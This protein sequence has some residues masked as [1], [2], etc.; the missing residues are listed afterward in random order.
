MP[1]L[2][3]KYSDPALNPANKDF[4]EIVN[5][6]DMQALNDQGDATARESNKLGRA[7]KKASESPETTGRV[8]DPRTAEKDPSGFW[9]S[10]TKE[11]RVRGAFTRYRHNKKALIATGAVGG[12]ILS[13]IA[14]FFALL[15]LKFEMLIKAA[16]DQAAQV[17]EHAIEHRLQYL[18]QYYI[19][20]QILGQ[21][22]GQDIDVKQGSIIAGTFSAWKAAK[23]E[24][25]LGFTIESD[26][27]RPGERAFNWRL[28]DLNGDPLRIDGKLINGTS[29]AGPNGVRQVVSEING[30][31]EMRG[32]LRTQTKKATHWHQYYK[33]YAMRKTL[34]R[35][36]GVS[37]WAWLPD[38]VSDTLDNYAEKKRQFIRDLRQRMYDNTIGRVKLK[39]NQ[40]FA[41][42][43]AGDEE[44]KKLKDDVQSNADIMA[45]QDDTTCGQGASADCQA[46]VE[47]NN[48]AMQTSSQQIENNINDSSQAGSS[49]DLGSA[50]SKEL[51]KLISKQML[52]KIAGGIGLLDT[53]M[54]MVNS[55][56]NGALNQVLYDRNATA[57]IG[58]SSEMLAINDQMKSGEID[59]AQVG[60]AM[61]MMGDYGSSPVWQELTGVISPS[62]VASSTFARECPTDDKGQKTTLPKGETLCPDRKVIYEKNPFE[63]QSWWE[64]LAKVAATYMKSVGKLLGWFQSA[65]GSVA[66]VLGFDDLMKAL[67][68]DKLISAGFKVLL[69]LIYGAPIT[70]QEQGAD[71]GDNVIG[72]LDSSY[73]ALGQTGQDMGSKGDGGGLGIGGAVINSQ[74]LTTLKQQIAAQ[75]VE[76]NKDRSLA[77]KLFDTN[78]EN[79]FVSQLAVRTPTSFAELAALPQMFSSTVTNLFSPSTSAAATAKNA[80]GFN[81]GYSF[82]DSELEADPN[83]YNDETCQALNDA[84]EASYGKSDKYPIMVYTKSDPCA[85]EKV[86]AASGQSAF[87]K[88]APEY[89]DIASVGNNTAVSGTGTTYRFA[90]FNMRGASH[91]AGSSDP[92]DDY[93]N[94]MDKS[95][96]AIQTNNLQIIGFQELQT[97]QYD[98]LMKKIGGTYDI[99]KKGNNHQTENAIAWN[100]SLFTEVDTGIMPNLR[101]FFG[102]QLDDPWV[103]LRDKSSNQEFYVLNT[104]DPANANG[105]DCAQWRLHNAKQHVA[106]IT[107]LKKQG[108]PIIFTGDF[109]SGYTVGDPG[110]NGSTVGNLPENITYCVLTKN[111]TVDDSYDLFKQ[112]PVKCP[113][114]LESGDKAGSANG[115]DH[116]YVNPGTPVTK[117]FRI[118]GGYTSNGS[119]HPTAVADVTLPGGASSG[120]TAGAGGFMWPIKKSDFTSLTGC[121]PTQNG[122]AGGSG[123]AGIDIDAPNV[124]YHQPSSP[125]F[126]AAAGTVTVV[127]GDIGGG[128]S[129]VQIDVGGGL[130]TVYEHMTG[131]TKFVHVGQKVSA[132]AQIGYASDVG[133][134]GAHHLH[135]GVTTSKGEFGSRF[136]PTS[137]TKNPLD[138]L[139]RDRSWKNA[140][141]GNCTDSSGKTN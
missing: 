24:Q 84:R 13:A 63:G 94:R 97:V 64:G 85:L 134:T 90:S 101:Y 125:V 52:A 36:F 102:S 14:G 51:S 58:Y 1:D 91:T 41:C 17:P 53:I 73:F 81:F 39:S 25:K 42:L 71:A 140:L 86:V 57:Y 30:S 98:L 15:P 4:E 34:M 131:Y 7:E 74:Q 104:H 38:K 93:R 105:C 31:S 87:V 103:R 43:T 60:A 23:Y 29:T 123:H 137:G 130:F 21:A 135:F 22:Y 5:Q 112:R 128:I 120:E 68:I 92:K 20:Q 127:S 55:V 118:P 89:F 66:N 107:E 141:G 62:K 12:V 48:E 96:A 126:A 76:D 83:N 129:G 69:N 100:K 116:I 79:S 99:T 111:K 110:S 61:E 27:V 8:V 95:V 80:F 45:Q 133:A 106:F 32:F 119:D 65:V 11:S 67:H 113:N 108:L 10:G 54:R 72:G 9:V 2:K 49:V 3:D 138:Y 56:D 28:R 124:G 40:Y 82:T 46:N 19:A 50:D 77:E 136:N 121:Y 109:N 33:R 117:F 122:T 26:R 78:S 132:G 70:G 6:P 37:R 47:R 114:P 115:I 59:I 18:T 44:C 88:G 35:K 75:K 139:P 16:T